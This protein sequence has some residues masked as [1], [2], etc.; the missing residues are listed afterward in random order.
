MNIT[1]LI[2]VANKVFMNREVATERE[3]ERRLKKEGHPSLSSTKRNRHCEDRMTPTT[4]RGKSRASLARYQCAYC[5]E[6]TLEE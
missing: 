6:G 3:G 5:R 1:Q 4:R 2:E